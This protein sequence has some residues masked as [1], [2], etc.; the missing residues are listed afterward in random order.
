MRHAAFCQ[1][2]NQA[3]AP[4][5]FRSDANASSLSAHNG[6]RRRRGGG[7][8]GAPDLRVGKGEAGN[9]STTM[10]HPPSLSPRPKSA[11]QPAHITT[12]F[13]VGLWPGSPPLSHDG[14]R[15][16]AQIFVFEHGS[17]FL[18]NDSEKAPRCRWPTRL[19]VRRART[20]DCLRRGRS[21][22]SQY[23]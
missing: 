21:I 14:A 7:R 6:G 17:I 3:P 23:Q 20:T 22:G 10:L 1:T 18:Y 19:P 16:R 11:N 2:A 9:S 4:L 8:V 13:A 12:V 5:S 15:M